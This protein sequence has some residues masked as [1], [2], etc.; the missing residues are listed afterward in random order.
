MFQSGM[1]ESSEQYIKLNHPNFDVFFMMIKYIY[2]GNLF[3]PYE[4]AMELLS[5]ADQYM[6]DDLKD[7]CGVTL[8]ENLTLDTVIS[9]LLAVDT[10]NLGNSN[11][12]LKDFCILFISENKEELQDSFDELQ[13]IPHLLLEVTKALARPSGD[14][15]SRKRKRFSHGSHSEQ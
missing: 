10:H 11:S 3:V 9:I 6:L 15:S 2:S 5:L 8:K 1:R 7:L 4:C 12:D 14:P 13:Q